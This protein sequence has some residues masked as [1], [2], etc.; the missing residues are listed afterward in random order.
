M[1]LPT[2]KPPITPKGA[3]APAAPPQPPP[4]NPEYTDSYHIVYVNGLAEIRVSVDVKLSRNYQSCGI[5]A[6]MAFTTKASLADKAVENGFRKLRDAL[7]PQI[8]EAS[9]TL[10]SL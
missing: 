5:Q 10:D 9:D 6:G 8:K 4:E 7:S 1:A 2:R 3:P